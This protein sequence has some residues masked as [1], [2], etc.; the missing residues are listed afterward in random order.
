MDNNLNPK[1]NISKIIITNFDTQNRIVELTSINEIKKIFNRGNTVAV[2]TWIDIEDITY[3]I[4]EVSVC[5]LDNQDF[6]ISFYVNQ[7]PESDL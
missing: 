5:I 6:E 2:D 3:N 7:R 1:M 4:V